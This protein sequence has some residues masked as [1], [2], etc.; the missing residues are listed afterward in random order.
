MSTQQPIVP[1]V[2]DSPYRC[3]SG[4]PSSL[5]FPLSWAHLTA[6]SHVNPAAFSSLCLGLTLP[7]CPMSTQQPSVPSV[8]GSPYRCVSGQPSR[9]QFPLSWAY[10][11][12]VSHVNPAAFS[13]LCLGLTLPL[14]P[15]STQQPS[16]PSVLG[17][18]YRCVS[19]QPSSLQFPLSWAL[20][21]A[22]SQFSL[23]AFSSLCLG[24]TLP[25]CLSSALQPSVPS[26]LGSPYRCVSGQPSSLQFPLSWAHLTAVSHVSPAAFSSLCLGLT[27]PLCLRS[28]QQPSVLS[29]LGSLSCR[30]VPCQPSSLQFPLSWAHLIAVSQVSLAAFSSLCLGL[31]LP[32]CLRSAQQPSV[33]SVL[34]SP[35]RCVPCQ[36][37]SLQFPLS[38]AHLT[39][40]SQ[41]NPAAFSSLCLGLS[42][43]LCPML[44]QQ[45]SVPSVLGS[46]GR[47]APCQPSSLQFPLSWALL[48]AVPHVSPAALSS[49]CLGLSWPMCPMSTQQ[50]SVPSVLG[51]PGRCAPCQPS[52]LQF[53]LSW[54]L[55]AAVPHVNPAA[56]SSLCLG[57]SWPMCP[58]SAQQPS[59]PSVLGSPCRCV[60]CQPSSLQFPLS[61]ALLTAVSHVNPAAFS[62]LCLG[63]SLPLCPM[64][65]QQ[66]SVPSVLGSPGRCAPCQPS[67]LQFPLSWALLAAVP[68]VNSAAFSSLCLGLSLP[69][70]PMSTQ[71]PSVRSVLGSPSRCAPCQPSSLQFPLSWALLADVPRVSPAAFSSLCLGLSWPMCP[72]SAQHQSMLFSLLCHWSF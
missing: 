63:L 9:L 42:L 1:S 60:P 10:L 49:L 22:V 20:L 36:P 16:V 46:P 50:P 58:M 55:L 70:C 8:L 69:M 38:W 64:S 17:S 18:P 43:S 28:A 35:Y 4:Q 5:P 32:L 71:Q 3:V 37:S 67:S 51:S 2:L 45:P 61:W 21:T 12:A 13:S 41:V 14:C 68:H 6:V 53:P 30:C 62:S 15:M 59:V 65:T 29:V 7:L 27:L 26:V 11:T 39:A 23:A 40:V 52:S 48:A 57:L 34:G 44:A 47:C 24:L 33:P 54:A 25:L 19:G 72:V 66:P 31:S 56:F